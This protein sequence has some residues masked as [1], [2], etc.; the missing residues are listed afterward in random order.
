MLLGF[1]TAK[2][3]PGGYEDSPEASWTTRV[4]TSS[5]GIRASQWDGLNDLRV[6]QAA[7]VDERGADDA[8]M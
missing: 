3:A 5:R 1:H 6:L 8:R 2:S 4:P 7:A